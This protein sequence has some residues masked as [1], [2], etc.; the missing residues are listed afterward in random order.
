[1][2]GVVV[3]H[4]HFYCNL[5][6]KKSHL[7][8]VVWRIHLLSSVINNFIIPQ[9]GRF[10]A[11][12]ESL[13]NGAKWVSEC[14]SKGPRQLHL[15]QSKSKPVFLFSSQPGFFGF[16]FFLF[17]ILFLSIYLYLVNASSVGPFHYGKKTW[18]Q[19]SCVSII[20]P[21]I[22]GLEQW[23]WVESRYFSGWGCGFE[24]PPKCSPVVM[25]LARIAS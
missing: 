1:M 25:S 21:V 2:L 7:D 18:F 5:R 4:L 3:N 24:P 10:L 8:K 11:K 14:H 9:R 16:Q 20:I 15:S 17:S 12:T 23:R 13:S 22:T 19:F 6:E